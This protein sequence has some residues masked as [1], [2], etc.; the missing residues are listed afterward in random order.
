MKADD[1]H[2]IYIKIFV[3]KLEDLKIYLK[4]NDGVCSIIVKDIDIV[5]SETPLP[6]V[7]LFVRFENRATIW[8]NWWVYYK[9]LSF[10]P[11]NSVEFICNEDHNL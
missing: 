7:R 11:T 9:K 3:D 1:Y 5:D 8:L 10:Y 2:D 6:E 4:L